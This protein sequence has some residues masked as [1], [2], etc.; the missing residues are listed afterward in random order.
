[1]KIAQNFGMMLML[2]ALAG[3]LSP[4][5]FADDAGWY[6]GF[7]AGQSRAKIDDSRIAD[8]LLID[9]FA[10]TSIDNENRKFA[11]K[12][13]GGYEFNRYFALESG[14]FDLGQFGFRADTLPAGSLHGDAKIMGTNFDAVGS[15]PIGDKFSL[16]A[17][18][19]AI[20]ARSKDSF[21]GTGAVAVLDASPRKWYADYKYG[22]GA[23]YDFTRVVG[24]RLEAER[25]RVDDAVGN[26]GDIDLYTAGLIIKF[27]RG[28]SPP[29]P[30]E[31][32]PEPQPVAAAA[33]PPPPPPPP[34][35]P[36]VRKQ[37]SFSADSLFDFARDTV[38]PAGK[39]ALNE[40]AAQLQGDRFRFITVTGHTDRIG[41]HEYNLALST[42]RAESVKA[43]LVETGVPADKVMAR[44]VDGEDPVTKP[45]ECPG[46][47]RTPALI[48]CLQPDRRVDVE[49]TAVETEP[50]PGN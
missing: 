50:T 9:G 12:S 2:A 25:Y 28:E 29:P 31:V 18:A 8:D 42:R 35:A 34:P 14:F 40:F 6:I 46:R 17:R 43:Y 5:A 37:V 32:A 26:K 1:M 7:N 41:S 33:P 38:R 10:T 20:Y 47:A 15:L 45:D 4:Q 23:Q 22:F 49:V 21:G 13:F 27:G 44:G 16:F 24:V 39:V 3:T 30:R 11:F 36:P 48:A 19:G